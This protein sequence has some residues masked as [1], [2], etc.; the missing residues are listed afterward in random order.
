MAG[1][2]CEGGVPN[3]GQPDSGKVLCERLSRP[4]LGRGRRPR[5]G[6][7]RRACRACCDTCTLT[8]F[9]VMNRAAR[10]RLV[11][12]SGGEEVE[13]L[14]F[15]RCEAAQGSALSPP[16]PGEAPGC[17]WRAGVRGARG[18]AHPCRGR[19]SSTRRVARGPRPGRRGRAVPLPG[20]GA[21]R[22]RSRR[23]T[24][25][26]GRRRP[27]LRDGRF[28]GEPSGVGL[29][30]RELDPVVGRAPLVGEPACAHRS[31]AELPGPPGGRSEL[32]ASS[33]QGREPGSRSVRPRPRSAGSRTRPAGPGTTSRSRGRRAG[34]RASPRAG[35][36]SG[37]RCP[38]GSDPPPASRRRSGVPGGPPRARHLVPATAPRARTAPG[39]CGQPELTPRP[40][41]VRHRRGGRATGAPSAPRTRTG[42]LGPEGPGPCPA[43]NPHIDQLR[44]GRDSSPRYRLTSGVTV[45]TTYKKM[46][47][48]TLHTHCCHRA[49][50]R[51]II[52]G[53]HKHICQN[54]Y[55]KVFYQIPGSPHME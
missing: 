21:A 19:C 49:S 52:R 32:R 7:R 37:P 25:P 24:A 46:K 27:E 47:S 8:V 15:A 10:D 54:K 2:G 41:A 4:D 16:T 29:G 40:G 6:W 34:R 20:S 18:R 44:G 3:R 51:G 11:G 35:A 12:G 14:A 38:M 42:S 39:R 9:S 28:S 55:P 22:G 1:P 31:T 17:G 53:I 48:L 43:R 50:L 45:S 13:D 5:R 36:R 33:G 30:E 26:P 23:R